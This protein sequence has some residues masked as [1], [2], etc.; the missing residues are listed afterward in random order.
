M[1]KTSTEQS[2]FELIK[3]CAGEA[4]DCSGAKLKG[5][6]FNQD[7]YRDYRRATFVIAAEALFPH[8]R[9]PD[10]TRETAR[11]LAALSKCGHE[12]I[13]P[14]LTT[15][16]AAEVRLRA[17]EGAKLNTFELADLE[18]QGKIAEITLEVVRRGKLPLNQTTPK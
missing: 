11:A 10:K 14:I 4:C 6:P 12:S 1:T 7:N 3:E 16:R 17:R 15:Y 8:W 2:L 13:Y 5:G 18:F 9:Q